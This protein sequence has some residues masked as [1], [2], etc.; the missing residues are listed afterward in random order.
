[1]YMCVCIDGW[2]DKYRILFKHDK[3]GNRAICDIM[4]SEIGQTK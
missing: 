3:E 1:M 4:L 2:I